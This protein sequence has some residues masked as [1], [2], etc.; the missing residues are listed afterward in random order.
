MGDPA[1][2]GTEVIV[3]ALQSPDVLKETS[4]VIIANE[5]IIRHEVRR[6]DFSYPIRTV[7]DINPNKVE[8]NSLY[9]IDPT[10]SDLSICVHGIPSE[11]GGKAAAACIIK[12]VELA[13]AKKS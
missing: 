2:I 10:D 12:A 11:A 8:E 9:L 3:K 1:G 5:S 4:V 13:Q 7:T 6:P